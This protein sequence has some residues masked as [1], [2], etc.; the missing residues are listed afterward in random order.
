MIQYRGTYASSTLQ[1]YSTVVIQYRGT[2]AS[3]TLQYCSTVVIYI[4]SGRYLENLPR[5]GGAKI[6]FQKNFGGGMHLATL[7]HSRLCHLYCWSFKGVRFVK[8]GRDYVKG[9]R[10]FVKGGSHRPLNEALSTGVLEGR[11]GLHSHCPPY[12]RRGIC[13]SS[14]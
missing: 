12:I 6:G 7:M 4:I 10:D 11:A 5:G 8:G 1:Y 13:Y 14:Q 2:Y 3:S 9:G